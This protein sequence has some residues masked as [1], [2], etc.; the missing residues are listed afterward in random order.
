LNDRG[1]RNI[2]IVDNLGQ[3]DK[4]KNLVGKQFVD[5]IHKDHCFEWLDKNDSLIEAF[6]HLGACTSTVETDANYLL[7]N[8]YRFS[9]HLVQYAIRHGHR[10]IYASSAATYGDGT[11][12]FKDDHATL[13]EFEPLNMYGF[14]KHMFDLWLKHKGLLN[15]VVGLK[16][17]NVYGPNELHKGRMASQIIRMVP[18]IQKEGVIKLFK[19]YDQRFTDG[20]QQR[21][22]IYVKDVANVICDFLHSNVMG[23]YNVGTGIPCSWNELAEAVF[24][25]LDKPVKIE[26]IPM[27]D[28]LQGKYQ[29]YTAADT[30]KIKQALGKKFNITPLKYAVEDYVKNYLV[31][32][33]LW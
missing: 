5:V 14:S 30:T 22:F 11:K 6:I 7:E 24:K 33:K 3:T 1:F 16:F 2:I 31:P 4:W 25:A 13:D 19:S 17:F 23:I 32:G 27:P 28:D 21:D 9:K 10:F 26:Y 8:N 20:G 29:Y 15:N 12:G 18:Q